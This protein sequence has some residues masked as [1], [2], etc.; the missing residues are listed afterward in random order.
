MITHCPKC[1]K[2][3]NFSES[4][5]GKIQAALAAMQSGT[6][7]LKCPHCKVPMELLTDGSLADWR[8]Q[9]AG[10]P[11]T[12]RKRPE[13][14]PPPDVNWL[15]ESVFEESE[16]IRDIPK[17]LVLIDP[18]E[19]RDRVLAAMVESFFQ[20]VTVNTGAE[21]VEQIK[22]VPFD[23]VVLHSSFAGESLLQSSVHTLMKK[24]Q[25]ARRRYIFYVLVGQEFST[26][27]SLQAVS[28]SA[29]LV[30]NEKDVAHMKNIYR[31]GQAE[32]DEL[33]GPYIK[34]LAERGIS[35]S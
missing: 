15:A 17:V 25:M 2:A 24:M 21:A 10:K 1:N 18:G 12:G 8:Q 33:F 9:S 27:Y 30:V 23:S 19:I 6:L 16:T 34:A 5:F 20:P 4:Q 14:P 28:H 32:K 22:G 26:L 31:K 29:D 7:K 35:G 11:V 3:L 13:P